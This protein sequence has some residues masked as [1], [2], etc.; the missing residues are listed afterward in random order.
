MP[1]EK[2]RKVKRGRKRECSGAK[3]EKR[4]GYAPRKRSRVR[5][6]ECGGAKSEKTASYAPR[7]G[8]KSEKS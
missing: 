8:E 2:A 5:K 3:R 4:A 7:E 6:R 1:R